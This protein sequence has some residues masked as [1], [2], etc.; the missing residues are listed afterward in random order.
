LEE[1]KIAEFLKQQK[2]L[3]GAVDGWTFVTPH[4]AYLFKTLAFRDQ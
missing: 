3:D 4:L 1:V 2:D